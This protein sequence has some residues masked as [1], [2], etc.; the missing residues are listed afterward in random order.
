MNSRY[1]LLLSVVGA[2]LIAWFFLKP[3]EQV[4][5]TKQNERQQVSAADSVDLYQ[6][7]LY[8]LGLEKED[9]CQKLG[10]AFLSLLETEKGKQILR[11]LDS[12][13]HRVAFHEA[14]NAVYHI[15]P[16]ASDPDELCLGTTILT[17][18]EKRMTGNAGFPRFI[19]LESLQMDGDILSIEYVA[20]N[21]EDGRA[22]SETYGLIPG[23]HYT[24][25]VATGQT[26]LAQVSYE[27][28][29]IPEPQ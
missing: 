19:Q 3:S 18:G 20:S 8:L 14:R 6:V 28:L 17:P 13:H 15:H 11:E 29:G 4:E 10:H 16:R 2:T 26:V 24:C 25:Q 7:E 12:K 9:A 5:R 23:K 22:L 1:A 21:D 27:D